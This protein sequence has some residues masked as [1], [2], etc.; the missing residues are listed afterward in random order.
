MFVFFSPIIKDKWS[1]PLLFIAQYDTQISTDMLLK[2]YYHKHINRSDTASK[3]PHRNEVL[4]RCSAFINL[5]SHVCK[6]DTH[7]TKQ[8]RETP[9]FTG[10]RHQSRIQSLSVAH[11]CLVAHSC[12]YIIYVYDLQ[13]HRLNPPMS[14][15]AH[16]LVLLRMQVSDTVYH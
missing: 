10:T 2:R 1:L 14:T 15:T 11:L 12:S 16:I 5:M 9:P 8:V 3:K 7:P 13:V 6:H 4:N